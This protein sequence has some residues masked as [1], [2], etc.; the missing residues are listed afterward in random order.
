[1][2]CPTMCNPRSPNNRFDRSAEAEFVWFLQLLRGGPVNRGVRLLNR[3]GVRSGAPDKFG[4]VKA[5]VHI[6]LL[7]CWKPRSRP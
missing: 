2:A 6:S 3:V 4:E 7:P 1:M 5:I